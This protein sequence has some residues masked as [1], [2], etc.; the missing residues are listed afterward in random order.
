MQPRRKK[1]RKEV[2]KGGGGG[3]QREAHATGIV[4]G[5]P[6]ELRKYSAVMSRGEGE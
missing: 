2:W 5:E 4:E 6:E 1:A 3:E